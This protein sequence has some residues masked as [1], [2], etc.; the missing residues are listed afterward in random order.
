MEKSSF[1]DSV[2][3][4][5]EFDRQYLA[6]DFANYFNSFIA[7]GIFP[8]PSS[9]LQVIADE[10]MKVKVSPGKAWVNGYFYENTDDLFLQIDN[11]DG[12]LSRIDRVVL[13]L[14]LSEEGRELRVHIKKGKYSNEPAGE[15]LQ[16]DAMM[17]ELCLAEL[18]INAGT[19]N[20]RQSNITDTRL[21]KEL[22]GISHGTIDQVD[23]ET[24]FKQY[25]DWYKEVTLQGENDI[26][27]IIQEFDTQY[28]QILE[29]W[30]QWFITTTQAKENEFNEWFSNI[31]NILDENVAT[32][33]YAAIEDLQQSKASQEDV[34]NIIKDKQDRTFKDEV[35]SREYQ[36][37]FKNGQMYKRE[38][39]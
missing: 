3:V 24:L 21:S 39:K 15:D 30:G 14:D 11:A 36:I 5:G 6:E 35:N 37:V 2:V 9:Q 25:Q 8:N 33:L 28:K 27:G 7:N 4:N 32:K 22:C 29:D 13:R 12:V 18:N 1:F 34:E 23:T 10:G 31:K 38:V 17:Y 19:V 20:I 16:R 26:N